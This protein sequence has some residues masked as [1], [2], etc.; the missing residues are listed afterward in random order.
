[1]K[2]RARSTRLI[3]KWFPVSRLSAII[4]REKRAMKP[5]YQM[6]SWP[7]RRAGSEFRAIILASFLPS[8]TSPS[9]FWSLF[10]GKV[11]LA[12]VL[13][14]RPV[15]LDPFMGGGTTVVEALRLGC[16][17]IGI[18]LNPV[19]WFITKK[20]V[21]P[22]SIE[23]FDEAVRELRSKIEERILSYYRTTCP[24]CKK[25]AKLIRA[26]WVRQI[27]CEECGSP[28]PLFQYVGLSRIR[29]KGWIYCYN[30]DETY[31]VGPREGLRIRRCPG[32]GAE[33]KPISNGYRYVCQSC[34]HVGRVTR[35]VKAIGT[36]PRA[37]MYAIYYTC[38]SCGSTGHK[39]PDEDDRKLVEL[40][41][42]L[43]RRDDVEKL[44]KGLK[45]EI[46][47]GEDSRRILAYG[48]R[49]FYELFNSRQLWVLANI[50]KGILSLHVPDDVRELLLLAFSDIIE[51]NNIMVPWT[52]VANKVESCFSV[53]NYLFSHMYAEINAW[54]GG[55][56]S[57]INA[58][59]KIRRGKLY[60]KKPFERLY[61]RRAGEFVLTGRVYTG[62]SC[63]ARIT[64]D[65]DRFGEADA[66]LLCA[67]SLAI[68][69]PYE[70]DAIITDPPY[71]DNIIYS[72]L[73]D[74]NY[75]WIRDA[76]SDRY[77][78][79]SPTLTPREDEIVVDPS[80]RDEKSYEE[81][82]E[83][84]TS[85]FSRFSEALDDD[86]ILVLTFH[87]RKPAAWIAILRALLNSGFTIR[88]VWPVRSEAR[89]YPHTKSPGAVV[90]DAV[91][92]ARKK[93]ASASE[94]D[95]ESL[96]SQA[97]SRSI[98]ILKNMDLGDLRWPTIFTVIMG[99]VL[100]AYSEHYPNVY[101][102]ARRAG[103]SD[104]IDLVKD[105]IGE[106]SERIGEGEAS[107]S[108]SDFS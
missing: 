17:A 74:M 22:C 70:V 62:G 38:G 39:I 92:V 107:A 79:F 73:S 19:A 21:E 105:L 76:L 95:I 80:R 23:E 52:Y 42:E 20:E 82:T 91:M 11:D 83:D 93:P 51:F 12:D 31:A 8:N 66:L 71:F 4:R 49:T 40:C 94:I 96:S 81:Y 103:I 34:G 3:E 106:V 16:K 24:V 33:L 56:G 1:M 57:F 2:E 28:I 14:H 90:Y 18:E 86:G 72:G 67:S 45:T 77:P 32:C 68:H 54:D 75:V 5:V 55:R 78:W 10:Y 53:H 98:Q 97:I 13:G 44:L 64:Y 26:Y 100:R 35:A 102:G 58:L 30:C 43:L 69:I 37:R 61:R 46:R 50:K 41:R 104:V 65:I 6:H 27:K 99:Q 60:C 36:P 63:E 87:H 108:L 84:M 48:I 47:Y 15:I 89:N 101:K 9:E 85:V 29:D 25:R 88:A 59:K 7:A